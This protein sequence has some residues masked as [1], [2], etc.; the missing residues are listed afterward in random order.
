MDIRAAYRLLLNRPPDD[1]GL[2]YWSRAI[3]QASVQDVVRGFSASREFRV[4]D[5]YHHLVDSVDGEVASRSSA[6]T[7]T[8]ELPGRKMLVPID[9][10][11]VG[12]IVARDRSY[13]PHLTQHI[14]GDLGPGDTF[15]DVGAN[16]GWFS[17][18]AAPVVG[19]G[20]RVLSFEANLKN[21]ELLAASAQLNG[22]KQIHPLPVGLSDRLTVAVFQRLGGSNGAI[23][24]TDD[25]TTPGDQW[26]SCLPLDSFGELFKPVKVIKID[27]EGAEYLVM[28]GGLTVIARDRPI[29]YFEYSPGML[30]RLEGSSVEAL[31]HLVSE[32]DYVIQIVEPHG[33]LAAVPQLVDASQYLED[34]GLQH[35]DL[36]ISPRR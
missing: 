34:R 32:L 9:D 12:A 13:E 15:I 10:E 26:I 35:L 6:F 16:L 8:V 18:A 5:L 22:F 31:Q 11:A 4:G 24:S 30:E 28:S 20:G 25:A 21:V 27:V 33:D 3:G 19:G 14:L 1:Q 17:L 2:R 36:R 7:T 29:I 23:F